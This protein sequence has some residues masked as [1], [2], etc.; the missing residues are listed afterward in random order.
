MAVPPHEADVAPAPD[1]AGRPVG[2]TPADPGPL[3]LA[4]FAGTTFVLSIFNAN[5]V[6]PAGTAVVLPLTLAFGGIAQLLAGMWEFRT[7]NTFGALA[8]SA[9]GAFWISLYLLLTVVPA[10][11]A[12]ESAVAV[13]LYSWAI[14]TTY[15]FVASLRTTGAIAGTF[16]LLTI[17]FFLLAI[18]DAGSDKSILHIGGWF[19]LATAIAAWYASFAGVLNATWG[20]VVLPVMPLSRPTVR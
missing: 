17:T 5:L 20:R 13:Y 7:G 12:T 19:G 16:F 4:A 2:W 1:P 14:F 11:A 15:M 6:N 9:Y 8:F 18:A 3:G 10:S